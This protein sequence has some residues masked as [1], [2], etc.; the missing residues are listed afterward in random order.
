MQYTLT[1]KVTILFLI[2]IEGFHR[3]AQ[4]GGWLVGVAGRAP[5]LWVQVHYPPRADMVPSF[6]HFR[7][8]CLSWLDN[9]L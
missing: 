2:L 1:L 7:S 5:S 6:S 9:Y 4:A 8:G 3:L